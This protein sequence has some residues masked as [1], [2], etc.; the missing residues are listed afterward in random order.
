MFLGPRGPLGLPSSVRL[1]ARGAK[2]LDQLYSSIA[3]QRTTANLADI[4]WCMSGGVWLLLICCCCEC[5][6]AADA[7][8]LLMC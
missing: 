7:L 6:D 5:A 2:N 1:S 8:M 4:V 3:H